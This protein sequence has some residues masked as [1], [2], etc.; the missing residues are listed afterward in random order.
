[1]MGL[2]FMGDVPFRTV[3]IHALVR[4]ARGQK[5][6]KSRGNIIDPLEL[7]DRYGCDALRFTLAALAAPGRDIKLSESRVEGYRNFATKL[8]NAARYLQMNDCALGA[9]FS[10]AGSRLTVNRWITAAAAQCAAEVTAALDAYRFDDAANRLYH[11]VWGTF[12][13]WYLEF[14]KPI[15]QGED[16]A[17][18][19]E[20]QATTAGSWAAS[21][22]CCTRLCRLLRRRYGSSWRANRSG[23]L[24]TAPWPE[25]Q[26]DAIDREASAEM[27]WVVQAISAIRGLRA[28]MNVPPAARVPLLIKDAEPVAAQRIA[29]HR[30]HFVRLARVERFEAV[31][32]LP[33]GGV[34]AVVEGATLVLA[35][36]E[37]V[38]LA[39]EKERLSK[40]I[41]R[42]ETEL[43]KIAAKLANP[44]FLAKAKAGGGRGAARTRGGRHSRSRSG[45]GCIRAAGSNITLGFERERLGR[46]RATGAQ[47]KCQRSAA[48]RQAVR[49]L[50]GP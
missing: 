19:A 37:V 18:R 20:T 35:L 34:Q 5:M 41:T 50:R 1:M 47:G 2:H 9:D 11:F 21:S 3:Y 32:S 16:A 49:E 28:E 6:S 27:E 29:R 38:D 17:A 26:R 42:L 48:P 24:I 14:T 13:D 45:Q 4:D 39:R 12:C 7:I 31:E 25:F 15:L 10:P 30:E 40:E 36:G 44:N 8:W 43:A 46:G 22:T 33:P 23:M